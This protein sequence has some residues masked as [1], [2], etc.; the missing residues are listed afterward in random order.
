VLKPGGRPHRGR[1][2]MSLFSRRRAFAN[3]EMYE[4]LEA[5]GIGYTI[6]QSH[7][8]EQDRIPAQ[9]PGRAPPHE[10]RRYYA[11]FSY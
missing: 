10:M 3:P 6:G 4:F 7:L 11:S 9:A 2:E 5:E 1:G 8:V